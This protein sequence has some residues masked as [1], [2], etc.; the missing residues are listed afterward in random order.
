M[1]RDK[2]MP[3][4]H[5]KNSSIGGGGDVGLAGI[6]T[7]AFALGPMLRFLPH[8]VPRLSEVR[9]D[10]VVPL[11]F[12]S[13]F[14]ILTGLFFGLAPALQSTRPDVFAAIREGARGSVTAPGR[15]GCAAL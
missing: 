9:I 2:S 6:A 15:I 12:L 1:A 13:L 14:S 3:A 4:S 7:A 8:G 5:S 11:S 10:W